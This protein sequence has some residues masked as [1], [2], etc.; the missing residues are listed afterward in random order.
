MLFDPRIAAGFLSFDIMPKDRA[1][2][3]QMAISK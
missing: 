3:R 2:D 1:A